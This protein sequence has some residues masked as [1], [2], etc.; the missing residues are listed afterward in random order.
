MERTVWLSLPLFFWKD[1]FFICVHW[2]ITTQKWCQK[3]AK[4][5]IFG[6]WL[7]CF[8]TVRTILAPVVPLVISVCFL[9]DTVSLEMPFSGGGRQGQGGRAGQA[10]AQVLS[11]TILSLTLKV[12]EYLA[13]QAIAVVQRKVWSLVSN[14]LWRISPNPNTTWPQSILEPLQAWGSWGLY[15]LPLTQGIKQSFLNHAWHKMI[16]S[17]LLTVNPM[18][19]KR[20]KY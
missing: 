2:V 13:M 4:Y 5:N 14:R 3:I 12:E 7:A 15:K 17:S 6:S 11:W 18:P 8:L 10:L 1:E 16:Y 19:Q 20:S 9:F